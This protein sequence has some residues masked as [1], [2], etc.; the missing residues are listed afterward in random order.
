MSALPAS[1]PHQYTW[2]NFAITAAGVATI[3]VT[4]EWVAY[5]SSGEWRFGN[6]ASVLLIVWV[7]LFLAYRWRICRRLEISG[8]L[9]W[10]QSEVD[11][12]RTF[13][14]PW[15]AQMLWFGSAILI[16]MLWDFCRIFIPLLRRQ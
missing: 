9:P 2:R 16:I 4:C 7:F 14:G 8:T 15:K 6:S 11:R 13:A 5:F 3:A 12:I 10:T 1:A